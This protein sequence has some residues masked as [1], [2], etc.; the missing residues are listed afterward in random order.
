M[1]DSAGGGDDGSGGAAKQG[2]P[3]QQQR[4]QECVVDTGPETQEMVAFVRI[5]SFASLGVVDCRC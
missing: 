4:E 2:E 5:A 1:M 3:Q